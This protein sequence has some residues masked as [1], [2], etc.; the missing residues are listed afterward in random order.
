MSKKAGKRIWTLVTKLVNQLQEHLDS[1]VSGRI[2][3][4]SFEKEVDDFLKDLPPI[5]TDYVLRD[6]RPETPDREVI[7]VPRQTS[8][9]VTKYPHDRFKL[10]HECTY[11]PLQEVI[12][13]L[14]KCHVGQRCQGQ[15]LVFGYDDVPEAKSTSH[16]LSV[17]AVAL[18]CCK[19]K[20]VALKT[21][22]VYKDGSSYATF[23][24]LF[25]PII[26]EIN[27]GQHNVIKICSDKVVS[28]CYLRNG[29]I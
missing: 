14:A 8:F 11:S 3:L 13:F 17:I 24:A 5:Y 1:Y 29:I 9:D 4:S 28:S 19:R 15:D 20:P 16:K 2:Y 10:M 25:D 23:D 7:T 26:N 27:E 6:L 18:K 12:N 22:K 21:S